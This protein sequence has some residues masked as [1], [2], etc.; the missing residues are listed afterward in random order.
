MKSPLHFFSVDF[1]NTDCVN[2]GEIRLIG[3]QI[4]QEGTV[5]ICVNGTWGS[6][7]DDGWGYEEA[8]VVCRELGYSSLGW[9]N[10]INLV[11]CLKT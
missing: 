4:A 10:K 2:N 1:T 6:V 3:G 5:E 7:C 8:E 9:Y 11:I